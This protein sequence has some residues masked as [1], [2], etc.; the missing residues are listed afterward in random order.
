MCAPAAGLTNNSVG[1]AAQAPGMS[2]GSMT[3]PG[4]FYLWSAAAEAAEARP[5]R[6]RAGAD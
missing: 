5:P 4:V 1:K 3:S 2:S 6:A